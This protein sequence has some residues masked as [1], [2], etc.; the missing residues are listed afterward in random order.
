[1]LVEE[2]KKK[3]N[4]LLLDANVTWENILASCCGLKAWS[5]EVWGHAWSRSRDDAGFR[6]RRLVRMGW[7][8]SLSRF[9]RLGLVDAASITQPVILPRS[10]CWQSSELYVSNYYVKKLTEIAYR[11]RLSRTSQEPGTPKNTQTVKKMK[12]YPGT[13]STTR[14]TREWVPG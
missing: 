11:Y 10:V 7:W 4:S 13:R 12:H 8:T 14:V 3:K 5:R 6:S 1:M 9:G 2:R